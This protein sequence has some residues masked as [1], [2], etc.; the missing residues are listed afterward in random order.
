V[1]YLH[2]PSALTFTD[3]LKISGLD[4]EA[5]LLAAIENAAAENI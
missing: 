2:S 4:E 1:W 5:A 3:K